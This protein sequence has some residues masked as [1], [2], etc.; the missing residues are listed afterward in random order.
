MNLVFITNDYSQY[1]IIVPNKLV[2]H[3]DGAK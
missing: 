3:G 1:I 2:V